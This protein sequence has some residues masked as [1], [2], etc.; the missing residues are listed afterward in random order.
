[1]AH[2]FRTCLFC[3]DLGSKIN[4][5]T[6]EL[7]FAGTNLQTPL[8]NEE[9]AEVETV[10]LYDWS[11]KFVR[12]NRRVIKGMMFKKINPKLQVIVSAKT[13][14]APAVDPLF[15]QAKGGHHL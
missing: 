15:S 9:F 10:Y 11:Y 6:F 4:F 5:L 13:S 12:S 2:V 14:K 7:L 1:M 8:S 3:L